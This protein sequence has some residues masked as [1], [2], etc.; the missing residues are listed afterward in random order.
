MQYNI[1]PP[2][3]GTIIYGKDGSSWVKR[4]PIGHSFLMLEVD[5]TNHKTWGRYNKNLQTIIVRTYAKDQIK[6]RRWFFI[7][8]K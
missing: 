6:R 5:S 8:I 7:S 3:F 2:L 1:H 4:W